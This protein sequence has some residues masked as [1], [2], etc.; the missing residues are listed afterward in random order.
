MH[1][2]YLL[3]L[4]TPPYFLL[5]YVVTLEAVTRPY[6]HDFIHL[7][8]DAADTMIAA[9]VFLIFVLCF[10]SKPNYDLLCKRITLLALLKG[11]SQA[12]TIVPQP[13]GVDECVGVSFWQLKSCADM[14]FSGH[15]CFTYLIL[16][17]TRFRKFFTFAM[18]FELVMGKWHYMSDCFIAC[19]AGYAI[20]KYLPD[21]SYL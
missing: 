4:V 2:F 21:E 3:L 10:L 5:S 12:L 9:L 8:H 19:I 17:K 14:M 16:Y 11:T 6:I 7:E 13:N 15:T 18:A 1:G 20:E